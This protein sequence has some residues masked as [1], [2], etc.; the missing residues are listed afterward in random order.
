VEDLDGEVLPALAEDV[1]LLLLDY[2]PGSMMRIDDVV[3][4][5]EIDALR[6]A[7]ELEVLDLVDG[8][9]RNG[10]LLGSWIRMPDRTG[11]TSA[12]SGPRG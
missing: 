11:V 9:L 3:A 7:L 10:V 12:D 8:C 1:L 5:R 2:L 6:L 4:D